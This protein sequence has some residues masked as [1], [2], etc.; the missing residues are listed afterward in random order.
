MI[1]YYLRYLGRLKRMV[2]NKSRVEGS[3]CEAYLCQE[4]SHFCSYYFES[5]VHSMRNRV[6]RNDDG[7][8]GDEVQR[9]LSIFNHPGRLAGAS[10]NRYLN[11]MEYHAVHL[12]ILMN[13]EEVQPY[14]KYVS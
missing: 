5:H 1:F 12:H 11:D 14:I 9:N 3:L 7:G 13:C 10:K 8:Q 6:G 4:T 2:K